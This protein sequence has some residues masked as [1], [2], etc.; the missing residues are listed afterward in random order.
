MMEE[1]ER[2]TDI[3]GNNKLDSLGLTQAFDWIDTHSL[4][5]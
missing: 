1:F 5:V 4:V 2:N 3:I